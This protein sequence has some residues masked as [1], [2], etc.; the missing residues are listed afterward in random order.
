M[1]RQSRKRFA[2]TVILLLC[3]AIVLSFLF[4]IYVSDYYHATQET[5]SSLLSDDTIT[6]IKGDHYLAMVPTEETEKGFIFYP[7]GK[8]D[9]LAYTPLM[10][11]LAERGV[12]CIVAKMPFQLA[13]FDGNAAE[14]IRTR[15]PLVSEWYIGGHSLGGMM[16]ASCA[17]RNAGEYCGVVLLAAYSMSDLSGSS[18]S[19][20]S[21]YGSRDSVLN[22]DK[23]ERAK[24]KW[25]S[26]ATEIVIEGANHAGYGNY[27]EQRDDSAAGI[28]SSEQQRQTVE[29]IASFMGLSSEE[30][31]EVAR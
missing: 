31:Q 28:D 17:A 3:M 9:Y 2:N 4:S 26:D 27:G 30:E 18:L 14:D 5:A 10:R 21:I 13:I 29:A 25:P 1:R 19:L 24:S 12:V 8:V 20:L 11:A 6:V 7:G 15:Y 23:Y 22:L 16:A